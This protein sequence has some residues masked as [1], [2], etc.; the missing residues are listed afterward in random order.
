MKHEKKK[1]KKVKKQQK[2]IGKSSRQ[3]R[4]EVL[5]VGGPLGDAASKGVCCHVC[6]TLNSRLFQQQRDQATAP[7]L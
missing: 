1:Q 3:G 6:N 5:L 7:E 4:P 2:K